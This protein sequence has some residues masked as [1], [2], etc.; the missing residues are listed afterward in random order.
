MQEENRHRDMLLKEELLNIEFKSLTWLLFSK[1]KAKEVF[2]PFN[3]PSADRD[4]H[5][6]ASGLAQRVCVHSNAGWSTI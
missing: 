5:Y 4:Q 3:I 1:S 6:Y 2:S